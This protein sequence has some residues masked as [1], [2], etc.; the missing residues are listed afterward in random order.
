MI[1]RRDIIRFRV[2]VVDDLA[3][4]VEVRENVLTDAGDFRILLSITQEHLDW[5]LTAR[6]SQHSQR[7][8][9]DWKEFQAASSNIPVPTPTGSFGPRRLAASLIFRCFIM[10]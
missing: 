10:S 1:R 5:Q 2:Y 7:H 4:G 9:E 3:T 8:E 6:P